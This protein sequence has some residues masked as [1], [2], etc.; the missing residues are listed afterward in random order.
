MINNNSSSLC[1]L[2]FLYIINNWKEKKRETWW[3]AYRWLDDKLAGCAT[4]ATPELPPISVSFHELIREHSALFAHVD[5]G[6]KEI[7]SYLEKYL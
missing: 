6:L 2:R 5:G 1:G 7:F 3:V 4:R